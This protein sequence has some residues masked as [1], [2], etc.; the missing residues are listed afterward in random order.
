VVEECKG[1][2]VERSQGSGTSERRKNTGSL[3]PAVA[4]TAQGSHNSKPALFEKPNPKGCPTQNHFTWLR[5][6][7]PPHGIPGGWLLDS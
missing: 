6:L 1:R 4:E 2:R 7:H 5:M 3:L